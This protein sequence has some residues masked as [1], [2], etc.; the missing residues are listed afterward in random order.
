[1]LSLVKSGDN[2]LNI[3]KIIKFGSYILLWNTKNS[4]RLGQ[5]FKILL[6]NQLSGVCIPICYFFH[7]FKNALMYFIEH[8]GGS[9]RIWFV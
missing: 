2:V 5:N 4:H 8:E 7:K 6:T 1:M 3:R 9:S